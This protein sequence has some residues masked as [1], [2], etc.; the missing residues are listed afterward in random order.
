MQ[1]SKNIFK[2]RLVICQYEKTKQ[3]EIILEIFIKKS[4]INKP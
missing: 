1:N 2:R 4:T 3:L